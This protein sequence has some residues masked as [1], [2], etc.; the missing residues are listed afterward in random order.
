[1]VGINRGDD[2]RDAVSDSDETESVECRD[3]GP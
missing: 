3:F 1:M 2:S